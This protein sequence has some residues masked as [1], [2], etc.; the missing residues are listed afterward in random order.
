MP[1]RGGEPFGLI[2]IEAGASRRPIVATRDGGLPEVICH[3]ENGFLVDREDLAG[4]VRYTT[5]L[6]EEPERRQRMGQRAREIV[7]DR[8]TERPVRDLER[9]YERLLPGP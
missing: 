6:I 4:L 7:E 9:V 1:S 2:S 3:G 5:L 8:F